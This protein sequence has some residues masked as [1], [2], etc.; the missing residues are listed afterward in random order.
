MLDTPER[1]QTLA[2]RI[3]ERTC[4]QKSMPLMNRTGITEAERD[5]LARWFSQ[6][7]GM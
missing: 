3:Y 5:V 7:A 2:P 6:G 4:V 1:I